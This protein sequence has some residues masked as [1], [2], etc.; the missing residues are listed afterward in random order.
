[1]RRNGYAEASV[2]DILAEADVS[3]RAFYRHFESKDALLIALFRRDGDVVAA[4][5]TAAVEAAAD[6]R[7][8]LDAW[9]E[10]Y[11]DLFFDPRR[12]SRVRVMASEAAQRAV[13]YSDE[14][15]RSERLLVTPL[16]GVLRALGTSADPDGDARTVLAIATSVCAPP[17]RTRDDARRRI[18]RFAWPALGLAPR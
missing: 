12:A 17:A 3:T 15:A 1:M 11:L 16:V 5:L 13:G 7:G 9:L 8:A 18:E 2:A 6:P 14:M 10:R 4:E